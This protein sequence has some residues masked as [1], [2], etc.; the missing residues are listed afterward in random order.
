MRLVVTLLILSFIILSFSAKPKIKPRIAGGY[1]ARPYTIVFLV[2]IVY[3]RTQLSALEFGAGTIISNQWILTVRGVL[4]YQYIEVHLGSKRAYWGYDILRVYK[5]NFY[6]HYDKKRHIALVKVPYQKFDYRLNRLR[7]PRSANALERF[8]GGR[9]VICGWGNAKSDG[10][11][12]D[13][14]RCTIVKVITNRECAK[15]YPPLETHEMCTSGEGGKGVCD[16]DFGG[17]VAL[18]DGTPTLIGVIHLRPDNCSGGYPSIHI[19][20]SDHLKW[21][22]SVSGVYIP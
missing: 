1:P 9:T 16:G 7:V 19:R 3:A 12:P 10:E 14:M 8:A 2:G 13:W 22:R 17:A 20:V 15:Y 18:I 11:L 5:Q 21:I 6:F 4:M